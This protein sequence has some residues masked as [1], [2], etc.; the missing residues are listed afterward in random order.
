MGPERQDNRKQQA[1]QQSH[2]TVHRHRPGLQ[3]F[4]FGEPAQLT[5]H[6]ETAV[7]ETNMAPKPIAMNPVRPISGSLQAVVPVRKRFAVSLFNREDSV[8][9]PAATD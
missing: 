1:G 6:P 3:R 7:Q 8:E 5:D 9:R 4:L 2:H